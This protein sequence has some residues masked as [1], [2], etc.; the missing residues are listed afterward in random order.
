MFGRKEEVKYPWMLP[1]N[2]IFEMWKEENAW[3]LTKEEIRDTFGDT[4]E[5]VKDYRFNRLFMDWHLK[6]KVINPE[7]F[8]RE[9][10]NEAGG[11]WVDTWD[12]KGEC[13]ILRVGSVGFHTHYIDKEY[14]ADLHE[15][16]VRIDN[17][18]GDYSFEVRVEGAKEMNAYG[19]DPKFRL[20][21]YPYVLVDAWDHKAIIYRCYDDKLCVSVVPRKEEDKKISDEIKDEVRLKFIRKEPFLIEKIVGKFNKKE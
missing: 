7:N 16:V 3:D 8:G 9:A 13:V 21:D 12:G 17:K 4:K 15:E 14:T 6:P 1:E 5:I 11:I 19:V 20:G 2:K 10:C 18:L